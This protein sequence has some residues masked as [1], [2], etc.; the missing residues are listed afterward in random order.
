MLEST[1]TPNV[2]VF[3]DV[4][5]MSS[6]FQA[7]SERLLEATVSVAASIASHAIS[8]RYEVGVYV[9]EAYRGTR[10]LI[11]FAP[12]RNPGHLTRVLTGLAHPMGW[13]THSIDRVLATEGRSIPWTASI[14]VVTAVPTAPLIGTLRRFARAGRRVAIALVNP[15]RFRRRASRHPHIRGAGGRT[16][17]PRGRDGGGDAMNRLY[18]TILV[19][20]ELL[21]SYSVIVALTE[22]GWLAW[23][24]PPLSL[25]MAMLLAAAALVPVLLSEG[26]SSAFER[27]RVLVLP[28]QVLLLAAAVRFEASS[29]YALFDLAWFSAIWDSPQL[30]LGASAYGT[31]L[32]WR[33][34][35]ATA[36]L[37]VPE[38]LHT[39]FLIG[40]S[41]L[42]FALLFAFFADNDFDD[43][44]P[45]LSLGRI[46]GHVLRCRHGGHRAGEPS[47]YSQG[48]DSALGYR[49]ALDAGVDGSAVVGHRWHA[50]ARAGLLS[51]LLL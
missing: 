39:R 8:S 47:G 15:R 49:P 40:L 30:F 28:A 33:G 38:R 7:P 3:L 18:A 26:G 9:N 27:F 20:G 35:T 32:L 25:P 41:V 11:R 50:D 2:A 46:R 17:G 31:F 45:L 51:L 42:F 14:L 10:E 43:R 23:E 44:S 24:R 6:R 5:T 12:S 36:P 16:A 13:P 19:L 29:G 48:D 37:P 34:I 22:W 4:N 1:S 21:W